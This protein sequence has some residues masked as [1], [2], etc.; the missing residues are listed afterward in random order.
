MKEILEKVD[1]LKNLL[2]NKSDGDIV[3]LVKSELNKATKQPE[4]YFKKYS[5]QSIE[6]ISDNLYI[7]SK[8]LNIP[9]TN[10]KYY[11]D[12][13][14]VYLSK[15][16]TTSGAG[17]GAEWIPSEL[18]PKILELMEEKYEVANQ[19]QE[20]DMPTNP[21][22]LPV[23]LEQL[24]AYYRAEDVTTALTDISSGKTITEDVVLTA[25]K[26][27]A[28]IPISDEATED[29]LVSALPAIKEAIAR[30]LARAVDTAIING[31]DSTS[32][33]DSDVTSSSDPRKAFKG[34][35]KYA[36]SASLTVD[37]SGI[38]SDVA[39]IRKMRI[40]MGKY[41]INPKDLVLITSPAGY[42]Q[43]LNLPEVATMEQIGSDAVIKTGALTMIDGIPIIVSSFV[44]QDLNTNG[45]Y[46]S[47]A[48]KTIFIL[49]NKNAFVRGK[50]G[51]VVTERDRNI[52][53]Q[54][55]DFV[56]A[57][58]VAFAPLVTP[59]STYS[60]VVLGLGVPTTI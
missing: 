10:L 9:P 3:D 31:D 33:M 58:R 26:F 38:T 59:S 18:S 28:Y 42:V 12:V 7:L 36:L 19:F 48:D 55:E 14:K 46:E 21:Y 25:K 51:G 1:K 43:L 56:S 29:M 39:P 40:K 27:V 8:A 53:Y 41:G 20:F 57:R 15:A 4:A 13:Y 54:R 47:S 6:E 30:S 11:N 52:L 34:L 2:A 24:I 23:N 22:K 35:R 16:I 37:A 49:V 32:H 17:L 44:R 60:T 45:V 50:R 5:D